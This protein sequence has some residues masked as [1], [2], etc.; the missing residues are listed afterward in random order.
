MVIFFSKKANNIIEWSMDSYIEVNLKNIIYNYHT[1]KSIYNKN[2]I[3]IIKDNAY[4]HGLVKVGQELSK[5]NVYMLGVST[6]NEA[7]TLRKNMIFSPILLLGRCDD[8]KILFSFKITPGIS[9]LSQLNSIAKDNITIPIHLEI[10]T[11]MNRLGLSIDELDEA[12][13]I[14]NK[15]KLKL[16]G[17]YTHLCGSIYKDQL[18]TFESALEK[19]K[20]FSN[21][22]I[23]I[24]SS[25]YI[26]EELSYV[27]ALRIGL[28]LY[29]YSNNLKL[30]TALKY[31]VPVW[32][33]KSININEN[34]GY[35]QIGKTD[36]SGYIITLP[37]GYAT[38]LSRLKSINITLDNT[39]LFQIGKPCLDMM[40][41]FSKSPMKEGVYINIFSE[42][43]I[44]LLI[45]DN[46]EIVYYLLSSLSP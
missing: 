42:E 15:S 24:Q 41:F 3:A 19:F 18:K 10:E 38:S 8:S 13:E 32:K 6:L 9:S 28:S 37:I 35:D 34:I 33:C 4:G 29:G 21:L 36:D 39:K 27:T 14:I 25:N 17:I 12:I 22:V 23:H 2:I 43:N 26:E 31:L 44:H 30:K 46:E 20:T 7:I 1:I 45:N 5:N 40:M 16:K 11:G